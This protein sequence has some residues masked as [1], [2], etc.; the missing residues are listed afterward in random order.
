M[1]SSPQPPIAFPTCI[2]CLII[3]PSTAGALHSLAITSFSHLNNR[4]SLTAPLHEH[5]LLS[6]L[7]YHGINMFPVLP[8]IVLLLF[9]HTPIGINTFNFHLTHAYPAPWLTSLHTN[10]TQPI[11]ATAMFQTTEA[12]VT[13]PL[14]FPCTVSRHAMTSLKTILDLISWRG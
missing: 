7:H 8:S 3:T 12:K 2:L 13:M 10:Q 5:S 14:V 6:Y 11:T 1:K 4:S 9:F